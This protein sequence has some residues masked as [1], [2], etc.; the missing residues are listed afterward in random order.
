MQAQQLEEAR[1]AVDRALKFDPN[2]IVARN[3][4]ELIRRRT[5]P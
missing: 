1:Q 4:V 2:D 5:G 3:V